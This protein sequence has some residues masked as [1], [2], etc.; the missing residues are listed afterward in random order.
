MLGK[1]IHRNSSFIKHQAVTQMLSR[2][3]MGLFYINFIGGFCGM[4]IHQHYY[5]EY[6]EPLYGLI[7][8]GS[9]VWFSLAMIFTRETA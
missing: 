2:I 5:G 1:A 3:F 7:F 9:M 8:L 4:V 6:V